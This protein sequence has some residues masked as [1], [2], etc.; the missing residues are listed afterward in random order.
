MLL[1]FATFLV[2]I[3]GIVGIS[4]RMILIP[5]GEFHGTCSSRNRVL[6]G[7]DCMCGRKADEPCPNEDK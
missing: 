5:D 2:I 6:E 7:E 3:L 1:Y 4:V